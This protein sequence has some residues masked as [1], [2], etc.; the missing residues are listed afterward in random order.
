MSNLNNSFDFFEVGALPVPVVNEREAADIASSLLSRETVA[1]VLGSQ[2]DANFLLRSPD[3]GEPIGILKISNAAFDNE[4]IA[5]QT[6]AADHLAR[7]VPGLRVPVSLPLKTDQGTSQA[8]TVE[9]PSGGHS[10]VRIMQWLPGGTLSGSQHIEERVVSAIGALAGRVSRGFASFSH[11][12]LQRVLQWDLQHAERVVTLLSGFVTDPDQL[13]KISSVSEDAANAVRSLADQLPRQA[14]H[15]DLVDDNVVCVEKDGLR[16]PDGVIDFGDL[17]ES[18]AVSELAVTVTSLLHHDGADIFTV[19]PAIRAFNAER[20]LSEAEINALWPMVV[21]RACVL[22]VSTYQQVSLDADN[23]Y[24]RENMPAERR[25]LDQVSVLPLPIATALV[26]EALGLA[27]NV[28]ELPANHEPMCA[29]ATDAIRLDLTTGSQLFDGGTWL[30]DDIEHNA[31]ITVLDSGN[32]LV[33][34][35]FG[36]ARLSKS[37]PSYRDAPLNTA[38]GI[39]AW[40]RT[41]ITLSTPWAGT[42]SGSGSTLVSVD[43]YVVAV[44]GPGAKALHPDGMSLLPGESAWAVEPRQRVRVT[45]YRE[46]AQDSVPPYVSAAEFSGWRA[47]LADPTSLISVNDGFSPN[48]PSSASQLLRRRREHFA[49]VQQHYYDD[50]PQIERGWREFL[51]DATGRTYLDMV[52][53]VALLGHGHVAMAD[54]VNSQMR[55]LNTNSRFHYEAVVEFSERLAAMTPDPLDTVLLVNSGSEANDLALRMAQI[56]TGRK[57]LLAVQEAYHGWTY[58]SDAVS[59]STVDNPAGEE[60]LPWVKALI[61]PNAY[62]GRHR[63]QEAFRYTEEAVSEIEALSAQGTPPAAFIAEAVYGNAGGVLLPEGYLKGVYE[64]V[65]ASGG[66]AI[67][68]EVQVGYGRLGTWFWGFEQQEV[69]PDIVTVAKGMGNGHPIGAVITTR[70]IADAYR[71]RGYFFSSAAGSPVSSVVGLTVLDALRDEHLQQNA[72]EVGEHLRQRLEMLAGKHPIIGAV[73]GS[74]LYM[75]IELVRDPATRE[76]AGNEAGAVCRRLLDLGVIIQPTSD[77][78]NVLKVK[79]PLCISRES[80]DFFVDALEWVLDNG[81]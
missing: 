57:Q 44:S 46:D 79:P 9:L 80:A 63:G 70:A 78:M 48:L 40:W 35:A 50:P 72:R 28:T 4:E 43:G 16:L 24:A 8:V 45:A 13:Q 32:A 21:L 49:R 17:T 34:T 18:W 67:A 30:Q 42:I 58:M 3:G 60:A 77:R 23:D 20:P 81:W 15:G 29:P 41:P 5:A 39:D 62:R 27:P 61:S 65:R 56:V 1:A 19:I 52:N 75:G 33:V 31:A 68:D 53:N 64:A 26:R 71:E 37:P 54:A 47:W 66:L 51:T 10:I 2:Q 74:G 11:T 76:P 59:T 36:E 14:V 7:S 22:A 12:R 25:M 69:V 38:T 6:E 73:H 55:L